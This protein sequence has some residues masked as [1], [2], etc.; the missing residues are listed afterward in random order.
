MKFCLYSVL[1]VML[2]MPCSVSAETDGVT[3]DKIPKGKRNIWQ[4][5]FPRTGDIEGT[6]LQH[7]TDTPLIEAEV[8]ILETDQSQK[9]R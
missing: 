6:V 2:M 3:E 7:G 8:R 9:N 5:V 4:R 1:C